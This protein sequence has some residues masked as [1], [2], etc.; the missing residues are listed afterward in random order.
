M[1]TK[2]C[3]TPSFNPMATSMVSSTKTTREIMH[4][5]AINIDAPGTIQWFKSRITIMMMTI[6]QHL[7]KL[8]D[9]IPSLK[10]TRATTISSKPNLRLEIK[11]NQRSMRRNSGVTTFSIRQIRHLKSSQKSTK[12]WNFSI[13]KRKMPIAMNLFN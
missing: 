11:R 6:F 13:N 3:I 10:K 1:I 4:K 8:M 9:F 7:T 2:S 5:D 12:I